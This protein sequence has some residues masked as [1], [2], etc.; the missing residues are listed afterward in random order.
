MSLVDEQFDVV[1]RS[2]QR[3]LGMAQESHPEFVDIF[4]HSLDEL[5]RLKR[6]V[7]KEEL[8]FLPDFE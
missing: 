8:E 3:G 4:Q 1:R 7:D 2:L 6:Q 5:D